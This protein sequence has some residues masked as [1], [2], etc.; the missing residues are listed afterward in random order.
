MPTI[1][2]EKKSPAHP[3]YHSRQVIRG[4]LWEK[5][6][7]QQNRPVIVLLLFAMLLAFMLKSGFFQYDKEF[8]QWLY[9][10]G[11]EGVEKAYFTIRYAERPFG[12]TPVITLY[13]STGW[14]VD[15]TIVKYQDRF[16]SSPAQVAHSLSH[17]HLERGIDYELLNTILLR[18]LN[19]YRRRNN[20]ATWE[21]EKTLGRIAL[22]HAQYV[23]KSKSIDGYFQQ[24]WI[25]PKLYTG[26]YPS[27]RY[28]HYS[29]ERK[30]LV[31]EIVFTE[32]SVS[33]PQWLNG[34]TNYQ[35]LSHYILRQLLRSK[36]N[37]RLLLSPYLC[38]VGLASSMHMESYYV[39]AGDELSFYKFSLVID[40][41][42]Y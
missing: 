9:T 42:R 17:I 22:N 4:Y 12:K 25:N 27:D 14:K 31:Q 38:L 8:S 32:T 3:I 21:P 16:V 37:R 34:Q 29:G 24:T 19:E 28:Q 23:A 2:R 35:E 40:M 20:L 41:A 26:H 30:S 36:R 13:D 10:D 15:G 5:T 33:V 6:I 39:L 18:D 11:P 1:H 7:M